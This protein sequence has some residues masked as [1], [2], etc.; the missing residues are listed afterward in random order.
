MLLEQTRF[1]SP[2]TP[3]LQK[4]AS[5]LCPKVINKLNTLVLVLDLLFKTLAIEGGMHLLGK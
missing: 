2:K 1:S 4:F 5:K 3:I